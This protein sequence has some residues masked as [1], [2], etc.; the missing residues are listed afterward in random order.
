MN[1]FEAGGGREGERERDTHKTLRIAFVYNIEKKAAYLLSCKV[2]SAEKA[3]GL[4][5]DASATK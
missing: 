3:A 4:C 1:C 2:Q 5:S